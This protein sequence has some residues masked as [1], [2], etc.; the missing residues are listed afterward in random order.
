ME[1]DTVPTEAMVDDGLVEDEPP[2]GEYR[3]FLSISLVSYPTE[4]CPE[5]VM[6]V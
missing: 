5:Y 1:E 4:I 3:M 2:T 6:I